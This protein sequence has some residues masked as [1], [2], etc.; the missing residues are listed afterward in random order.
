[1]VK[2]NLLPPEI[3]VERKRKAMQ[4]RFTRSAVVLL[5]VLLAGFGYFFLVTLQVKGHAGVL[6]DE[7]ARLEE[8]IAQ[9]VPYVTMR[10][11][12]ERKSSLL[13]QAMSTT[14]GWGEVLIDIGTKIPSNVWL[15][16]TTISF[17]PGDGKGQVTIRG[18]TYDHPSTARWLTAMAEIPGLADVRC[19]FSSEET[20]ENVDLVRFEV[21]AVLLPGVEYDPLAEGSE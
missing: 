9:Y 12:I 13:K 4:Q 15:T 8:K 16:D 21:K 10:D 2:I 3:L 11:E 20:V 6:A 18:L 19:V 14:P 7:R 17:N 1:M 5:I